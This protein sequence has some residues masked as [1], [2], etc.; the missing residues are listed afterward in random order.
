MEL[1]LER[2][3]KLAD[4][5][6]DTDLSPFI[7]CQPWLKRWCEIDVLKVNQVWLQV[8]RPID[9]VG[10][11]TFQTASKNLKIYRR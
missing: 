5:R 11:K 1:E 7:E 2:A 3:D 4:V 10:R 9:V 6:I 8:P